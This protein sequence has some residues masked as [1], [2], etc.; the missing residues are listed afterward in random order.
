M[1]LRQL[2]TPDF[3]FTDVE[4]AFEGWVRSPKPSRGLKLPHSPSRLGGL[5]RT[6]PVE[7]WLN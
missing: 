2:K 1:T 4:E 6:A 7:R 3:E 5:S